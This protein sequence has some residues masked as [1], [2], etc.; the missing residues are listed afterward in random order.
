MD[1]ATELYKPWDVVYC[2]YPYQ[3]GILPPKSHHAVLVATEVEKEG[4]V[5]YFVYTTS[6]AK[7]EEGRIPFHLI[8]LSDAMA[9]GKGFEKGFE[10]HCS[11]MA[12]IP[13]DR[14]WIPDIF[15]EPRAGLRGHVPKDVQNEMLKAINLIAKANERGIHRRA[16]DLAT[17]RRKRIAM[18]IGR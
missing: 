16:I 1:E 12:K 3:A 17:E 14:T 11:D 9:I 8:R 10:I 18:G 2:R 15:D 4:P 13:L 7:R 5:G 6:G